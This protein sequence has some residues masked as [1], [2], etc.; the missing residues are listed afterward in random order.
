MKNLIC[1]LGIFFIFISN[2][3]AQGYYFNID[4]EQFWD[5]NGISKKGICDVEITYL[6]DLS[7]KKIIERKDLNNTFKVVNVSGFDIDTLNMKETWFF[8][9]SES[10]SFIVLID[11]ADISNRNIQLMWFFD[12]DSFRINVLW[13]HVNHYRV[14]TKE[15]VEAFTMKLYK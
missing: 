6:F 9:V 4:K 7:N 1:F 12:K 15:H 13:Q 11:F 10:D 14:F 3:Y 2:I 8:T 5:A